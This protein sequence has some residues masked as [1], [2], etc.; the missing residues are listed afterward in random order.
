MT[1][2]QSSHLTVKSSIQSVIADDVGYVTGNGEISIP[3]N[4][5]PFAARI[6]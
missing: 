3:G 5:R 4:C 1:E 2:C 6:R